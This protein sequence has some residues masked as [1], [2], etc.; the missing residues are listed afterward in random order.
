MR[1]TTRRMVDIFGDRWYAEVQWNNIP[2]QLH[3]N[4]L[5]IEVANEFDVRLISTADSHNLSL[6]HI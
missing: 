3:L 5:I 6:I 2:E 4:Q 1:E